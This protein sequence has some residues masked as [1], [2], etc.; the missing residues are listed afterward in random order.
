MQSAFRSLLCSCDHL[1]LVGVTLVS[2]TDTILMLLEFSC[3][4]PD[5]NRKRLLLLDLH[6]E[7]AVP[8]P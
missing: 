7:A 8:I 3:W 2:A 4:S 6:F 5:F 1:A